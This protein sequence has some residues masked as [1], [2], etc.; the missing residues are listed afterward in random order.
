MCGRYYFKFDESKLSE[1]IKA[2]ATSLSLFIKEGEIFPK[3]DVLVFVKDTSSTIDIKTIRW[4]IK[5]DHY[6]I[7]ARIETIRQTL[8]YDNMCP[9]A[10]FA[11]GFYEWS[12][13]HKFYVKTN[14]ELIY[15]AGIYD[16]DGLLI[17]TEKSYG[18]LCEIHDRIPVILNNQEM[19]K[20][21]LGNDLS[22]IHKNISIKEVSNTSISP[23]QVGTLN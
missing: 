19:L 5:R 16:K 15:L 13:K 7:N 22:H 14:D 21:L 3:D 10:I 12:K 23:T 11:S 1:K 20:Y 9:C 2:K 4:G 8:F 6:M 18:P 17:V